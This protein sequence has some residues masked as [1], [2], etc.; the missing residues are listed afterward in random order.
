MAL[1]G[2]RS[3]AVT[4]AGRATTHAPLAGKVQRKVR[5]GITQWAAAGSSREFLQCRRCAR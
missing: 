4:L 5:N 2:E 3:K 1:A